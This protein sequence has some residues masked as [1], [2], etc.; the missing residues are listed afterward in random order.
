MLKEHVRN[1]VSNE[2]EAIKIKNKI[3]SGPSEW[4]VIGKYIELFEGATILDQ[5]TSNDATSRLDQLRKLSEQK[6]VQMYKMLNLWI[7]EEKLMVCICKKISR[8]LANG[9][10]TLI[11][12][13]I[14]F[15]NI[16]TKL[17]NQFSKR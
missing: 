17:E 6:E 15:L 11:S 12:T 7:R 10:N 2:A 4:D 1:Y 8:T 9:L 5:F 3:V 16:G 13:K 14:I